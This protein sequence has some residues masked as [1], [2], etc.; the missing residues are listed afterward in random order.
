[1][2]L[3]VEIDIT[4]P[5]PMGFFQKIEKDKTWI[6]FCYERLGGL[7]FN[8]GTLGHLKNSCKAKGCT[9]ST[10]EDDEYGSWL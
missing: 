8:C 1:M 7:C 6:Q 2:R 5:I 3:Q 9:S 10:K 4:K